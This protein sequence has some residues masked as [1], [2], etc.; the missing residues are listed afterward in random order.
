VTCCLFPIRYSSLEVSYYFLSLHS[1]IEKT[2]I[3]CPLCLRHFRETMRIKL[4]LTSK[5]ADVHVVT[6]PHS[7][8]WLWYMLDMRRRRQ[9]QPTPVLLPGKSWWAALYEVPQSWTWL[10]WVSSS[11]NIHTLYYETEFY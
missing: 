7:E 6:R 4:T 10:K 8:L 3:G 5:N 2:S 1:L 11:S 9:W